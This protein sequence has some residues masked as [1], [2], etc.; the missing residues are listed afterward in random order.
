MDH[1]DIERIMRLGFPSVEY[2]EYEREVEEMENK[3]TQYQ[4]EAK[5]HSIPKYV[6]STYCI[7]REYG[8]AEVGAIEAINSFTLRELDT[9][10]R[11][12][13]NYNHY[14]ERR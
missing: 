3:I 9:L 11:F 1:P 5:L 2:L 14:F 4:E 8:I 12:V 6:T 7:L 10:V 13:Q